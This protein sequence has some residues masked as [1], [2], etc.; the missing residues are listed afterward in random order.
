MR[1]LYRHSTCAPMASLLSARGIDRRFG[2]ASALTAAHFDLAAGEV[3]GLKQKG[4]FVFF[5]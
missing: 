3:R 5:V 1:R 2:G 4:A